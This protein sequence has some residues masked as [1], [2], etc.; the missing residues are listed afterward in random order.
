M[1]YKRLKKIFKIESKKIE[2][3]FGF[4]YFEFRLRGIGFLGFSIIRKGCVSRGVV[5]CK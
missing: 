4:M 1:N 3:F 2:V 5:G